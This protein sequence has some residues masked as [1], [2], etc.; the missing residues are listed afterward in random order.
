MKLLLLSAAECCGGKHGGHWWFT[1][2]GRGWTDWC[3]NGVLQLETLG[4]IG[5]HAATGWADSSRSELDRSGAKP[6]PPPAILCY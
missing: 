2:T 4:S 3:V 5:A 6:P 1:T